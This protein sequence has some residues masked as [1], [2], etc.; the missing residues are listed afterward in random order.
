MLVTMLG[1]LSLRKNFSWTFVGNVVSAACQWGI[2]TTFVKLGSP[3]MVGKFALGLAITVPVTTFA[4]LQL[5]AVQVT[6]AKNEYMFRDYF[7]TR[8]LMCFLGLLVISGIAW[9]GGYSRETAWIVFLV[10]LIKTIAS[11]C[12]IFH[13]LFQRHER[14]NLS[15]CSLMLRNT[16]ALVAVLAVTLY[17]KQII[18]SLVAMAIVFLLVLFIYDI[19]R[20]VRLLSFEAGSDQIKHL[21]IPRF[22]SK[23]ILS[24]VWLAL[25]LGLVMFLRSLENSVPRYIL[26]SF[27]GEAALGYFAA[28]AYPVVVSSIVI[29]AIGQS[30]SPKLANYC[31]NN[32]AAY[33]RLMR[34]LLFLGFIMG[35][36]F[37]GGVVLFGKLALTVVYSIEYANYD[38]EF[39]LLAV[40]AA[41]G[42]MTSFYGYSFTA[43][44]LFKTLLVMRI[45]S[46]V[47]MVLVSFWLI[48]LYGLCGAA[49]SSIVTLLVTLVCR[50][51]MMSIYILKR[52]QQVNI[53]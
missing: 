5:R 51:I 26:E 43:A 2:L 19:S 9:F 49:I 37:V 11:L 18:P 41:I 45:M 22:D 23:I 24:L 40:G 44:R 20:A 27:H 13:G 10:G 34:K 3:E 7:G 16:L 50:Y 8:L 35:L 48:P 12:D 31:V 4:M 52:Q 42:F 36:F 29:G 39:I 6:D 21:L 14:M 15:A 28:I 46:C 17:V 47:V 32:F 38:T 30:A 33:H 25:P 1:P 53:S